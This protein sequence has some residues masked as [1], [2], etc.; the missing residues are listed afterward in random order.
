MDFEFFALVVWAPNFFDHVKFKVKIFFEFFHLQSGLDSEIFAGGVLAS[1]FLVMQYLR[2][3]EF[4][5]MF[6]FTE[7]SGL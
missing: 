5:G 6:S 3:K 7:H 2:P 1:T 4:Y